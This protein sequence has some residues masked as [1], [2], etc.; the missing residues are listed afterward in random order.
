VG[1]RDR[2][3]RRPVQRCSRCVHRPTAIRKNSEAWRA[4]FGLKERYHDESNTSVTEHPEPPGFRGNEDDGR[5]LETVIR[6]TSY[7]VEWGDRSRPDTVGYTDVKIFDTPGC[8]YCSRACTRQYEDARATPPA[9]ETAALDIGANTLVACTTT[10]ASNICTRSG[11]CLTASVA[12]H[13][14]SPGYSRNSKKTDTVASVSGDCIGN[15]PVA[16]ATPE[17]R[18]VVTST[19]RAWTRCISAG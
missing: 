13:E 19:P 11:T 5:Q 4:F 17:K 2:Q 6:N 15:E 3:S 8:R 12:R 10:T 7:T 1:R 16:A 9:D 18:C 14:K